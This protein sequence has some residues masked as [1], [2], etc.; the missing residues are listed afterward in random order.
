MT[1]T[2]PQGRRDLWLALVI[3]LL[4]SFAVRLTV[5][6]YLL[7]LFWIVPIL[8]S[9]VHVIV[10]IYAI[11]R[12]PFTAPGYR[13]MIWGSHFLFFMSFALQIDGTGSAYLPNI[14][15]PIMFWVSIPA[16]AVVTIFLIGILSFVMLML[17]WLL[18]AIEPMPDKSPAQ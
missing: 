4:L 13:F 17:S 3:T 12:V 18:L 14:H 1:L 8:I 10:H 5:V 9:V 11:K 15:V 7:Y 2:T 6:G 16:N